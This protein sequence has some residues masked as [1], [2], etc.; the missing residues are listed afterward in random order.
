[1]LDELDVIV[2][3]AFCVTGSLRL[4]EV[5]NSST[6]PIMLADEFLCERCTVAEAVRAG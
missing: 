4:L 3:I 6:E 2:P 5:M 1:M